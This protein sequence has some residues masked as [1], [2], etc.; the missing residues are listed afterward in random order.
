[1]KDTGSATT[2]TP[3]RRYDY[4]LIFSALAGV[5]ALAWG[6]LYYL[7]RDMAAMD[8]SSINMPAMDMS[9]MSGMRVW[10]TAEFS[11]MFF[12]WAVMMVGMMVPTA[13]RAVLIY[14]SIAKR[15]SGQGTPVAAT[16]WFVAGYVLIWTTFSLAATIVQGL[17]DRL[18]LL[19][20]M[21]VSVS[22]ALG[23]ALLITA[24][25][26]QLSPWKDAC[27]KHCQSPAMYLASHF[28]PGI[29]GAIALGSRHGS[30]CLGCCWAI[31]ALLFLGGVMNLLW[32][33][34]ITS[35][36]LAEKLLPPKLR[37]ARVSGILMI[38]GGTVF[39]SFA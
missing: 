11:L 38:V 23:A 9:A 18:G 25:I 17:L 20:P 22:A 10:S 15:A 2:N 34:A 6:Y 33:A 28:K 24:G 3:L 4:I 16:Y 29:G 14:A 35:F 39:L 27:L 32:I 31:M 13:M 8:M 26:Y 21:M 12:M 1:V 36:V 30:Y 7:A 37:I 19:S 5:V